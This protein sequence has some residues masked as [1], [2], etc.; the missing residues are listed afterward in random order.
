M[1][2]L[3]DLY[4]KSPKPRV[5]EARLIPKEA[6][7]F[8]DREHKIADGF[9]PGEKKGDPT[10]FTDAAQQEYNAEVGSLTPPASYNPTFP[11]HRYTPETPFF[12]PGQ[13]KA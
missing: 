2:Q 4:N 12:D 11:L 8:F 13:P 5:A 9:T 10:Q 7:D 6:T 1:S 3:V